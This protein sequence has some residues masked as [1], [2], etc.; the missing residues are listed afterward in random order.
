MPQQ[1]YITTLL[2][3]VF[4]FMV[5]CTNDAHAGFTPDD[6]VIIANNT[7]LESM[8]LAGYYAKKRG[9][10]QNNIIGISTS[11]SESITRE[12]F[13]KT[14]L[15]PL[16]QKF[17]SSPHLPGKKIFVLMHGIPLAIGE[18]QPPP[19]ANLI[20]GTIKDRNLENQAKYLKETE[21]LIFIESEL[22]EKEN[23]SLFPSSKQINPAQLLNSIQQLIALVAKSEHPNKRSYLNNISQTLI[24][25]FG[26]QGKLFLIPPD[27]STEKEKIQR[28]MKEG[29]SLPTPKDKI[30]L[31]I[32]LSKIAE[33]FGIVGILQRTPTLLDEL[34]GTQTGA[35]VDSELTN[36]W[37]LPSNIQISNRQ[38]NPLYM[39]RENPSPPSYPL[40]LV[41]RIDGPTPGI[42]RR[43]IDATITT[44][45]EQSLSGKFLIDAR[46][47]P[48]NQRDDFG[49]WDRYLTSLARN[50]NTGKKFTIEYDGRSEL[51]DETKD[52]GLYVGWYQ[53]RQY[54]DAYSF[55]KGAI[56][57][58]IASSEA[59]SIRNP[60]EKGWCKNMLE[61]GV[62]ATLGAVNEPYLDS[63]PI[64]T[65][66]FNLLLSGKYQLA[67]VYYLTTKYISWQLVLFGDPLYQPISIETAK[68]D[69]GYSERELKKLPTPP[70]Q[71]LLS[72]KQMMEKRE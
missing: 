27:Q 45:K 30:N 41:S 16:K 17:E 51:A 36:F 42:V 64:P 71:H 43:N 14:I 26:Y 24:S 15:F 4:S 56:G 60:E 54:K 22:L 20:E 23:P 10:S 39:H 7:M 70:S 6:V 8:S 57:Y 32:Y 29:Y 12:E 49:T 11:T 35:S 28:K 62:V 38:P 21:G 47:I 46:G 3:T 66:F 9:I 44:E 13:N 52:I 65:D 5:F 55:K 2:F 58:H 34:L 72:A 68:K 48:W 18:T 40:M 33:I 59:M 25:L 67:E 53:V 1:H 19:E 50:S 31:D 69:L 61:R 37:L 63:F